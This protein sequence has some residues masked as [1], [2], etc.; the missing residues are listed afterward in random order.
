[1]TTLKS[2]KAA[3]SKPKGRAVAPGGRRPAV[4]G[5]AQATDVSQPPQQRPAPKTTLPKPPAPKKQQ[6]S[7][8]AGGSNQARPKPRT[9]R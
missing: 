9:H 5:D 2:H 3:A 8:Q 1:M 4:F 7:K 6:H